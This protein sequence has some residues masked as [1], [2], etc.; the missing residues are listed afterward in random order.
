M[1]A[2]ESTDITGGKV[3]QMKYTEMGAQELAA[4]KAAVQASYD[5]FKAAGRKLDMSRGKP[6]PEQLDLSA[7]LLDAVGPDTDFATAAEIDV[8]NY[9]GLPG[10]DGARLLMGQIM[11]VPSSNVLVLGSSSLTIMY[12]LVAHAMTHGIM[13]STPWAKLDSVKF[14]CPAP[15]YDRH[16]AICEHFGIEMITI[17]M[18]PIGPDMDLIDSL[19]QTDASIK[20]IWC[21]PQYSNPQGYCYSDEVLE[22]FSTLQPAAAD[23]RIFWDN[24][25]AVHHLVSAP[26]LVRNIRNLCER[27]GNPDL[28]Y[29]FASTSKVTFPGAG[30]AAVA[31]SDANIADLKGFL[32]YAMIGPDKINQLRHVRYF[33]NGYT[34]EEHMKK[35]A[36]LIKP[37]FD[38]VLET[39]EREL[40]GLGV[41]EWTKPAGGYFIT[42]ESLPGC[43]KRIVELAAE[44][45]VKMTAAGAM[46]PYGKDPNDTTIRIAPTYPSIEELSQAATL[47]AICVKLA[48]IEKLEA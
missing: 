19:V 32:K 36:A 8:R 2:S 44:A 10:I 38:M 46:Y 20:G 43:A 14:L 15:G 7:G 22:R 13:G 3:G 5:E 26:H 41:G 11:R 25:Y 30:I 16:F 17:P 28:Y 31:A 12:E 45:G 39:L 35:Q 34:V 29:E 9:G 4:E 23:F 48:S 47:F 6:G 18:S 33:S 40:G 24:A 42:F 37:K 27:A 1:E 21:V